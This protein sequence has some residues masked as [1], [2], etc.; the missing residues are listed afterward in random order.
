MPANNSV[1]PTRTG[2]RRAWKHRDFIAKNND[3][4]ANSERPT[5]VER[6]DGNAR[7][8]GWRINAGHKWV[9]GSA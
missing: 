7:E 4:R 6:V 2:D 1:N 3:A 5:L 8:V 9:W